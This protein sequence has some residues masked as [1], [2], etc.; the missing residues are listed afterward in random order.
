[1]LLD[2]FKLH[3]FIVLKTWS[4]YGTDLK[5]TV[6][7][8]TCIPGRVVINISLFSMPVPRLIHSTLASLESIAFS[9]LYYF[10]RTLIISQKG[11]G[12][13]GYRR[14]IWRKILI[15]HT[16][17]FQWPD[18]KDFSLNYEDKEVG[19]TRNLKQGQPGGSAV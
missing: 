1:M 6:Y 4:T 18:W 10:V 12:V 11:K 13:V 2:I 9:L 16:L 8:R 17:E 15:C 7:Y 3:L 5:W 14:Q 19:H